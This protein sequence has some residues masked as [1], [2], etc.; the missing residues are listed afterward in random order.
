MIFFVSPRAVK[1]NMFKDLREKSK[2][3]D[4]RLEINGEYIYV[5]KAIAI[6]KSGLLSLL[7]QELQEKSLL[8]WPP[9]N[10]I[11]IN[12]S[13]NTTVDNLKCAIDFLYDTEQKI[14]ELYSTIKG[15]NYLDVPAPIIVKLAENNFV[16]AHAADIKLC[17]ERLSIKYR[18]EVT[19]ITKYFA[20]ELRDHIP[21]IKGFGGLIVPTKVESGICPIESKIFHFNKSEDLFRNFECFGFHWKL[22]YNSDI[23]QRGDK[24]CKCSL[25]ICDGKEFSGTE[26][27]TIRATIYMYWLHRRPERRTILSRIKTRKDTISNYRTQSN[28]IKFY[29]KGT[30][31][32]RISLLIENM[33]KSC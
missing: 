2:Y 32:P 18:A 1:S 5:H 23:I 6:E 20:P 22:D 29:F 3:F 19:N 28:K 27:I 24:R 16:G 10:T 15:L 7:Y 11:E 17:L 4:L 26:Y 30:G 14:S 33:V 9:I 31:N 21:K 12:L 13:D 25:F 8:Q